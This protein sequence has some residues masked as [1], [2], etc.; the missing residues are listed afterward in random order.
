MKFKTVQ[1]HFLSDIFSLLSSRNFATKATW[2]DDLSSLRSSSSV[3][4]GV[5]NLQSTG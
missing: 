5:Q 1:I 3:R 4:D 2:H